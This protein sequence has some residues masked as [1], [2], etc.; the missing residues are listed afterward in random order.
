MYQFHTYKNTPAA[1]RGGW[2]WQVSKEVGPIDIVVARSGVGY[3]TENAAIAGYKEFVAW[4]S[5]SGTATPPP[6]A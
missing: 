2:H 6:A 5:G 4:A 3:A 1:V